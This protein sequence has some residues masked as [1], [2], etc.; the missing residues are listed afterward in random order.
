MSSIKEGEEDRLMMVGRHTGFL[1]CEIPHF[2]K[3]HFLLGLG[4]E[5]VCL[6]KCYM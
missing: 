3:S 4:I 2:P 6:N 1:E 5:V